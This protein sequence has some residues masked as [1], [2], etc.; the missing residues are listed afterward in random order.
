MD[1]SVKLA[2]EPS[3]RLSSRV[4]LGHWRRPGGVAGLALAFCLLA[5][6]A[7]ADSS[8]PL[9]AAYYDR[10]MA[11]ID[12]AAYVWQGSSRPKRVVTD[13]VQVGVGR[14]NYYVL[15]SSGDLLG[16]RDGFSQPETVISGVARFAAG[17]TGVLA[18]KP[19]GTLWWIDKLSR[20]AVKIAEDV[21]KA[22]V[23]DGANYYIT[24]S[25]ALYVRGKAHRGQYGDGRLA[26]TENFVT[27]ASQVSQITAH[28]GH[29]IL[30]KKNGDVLGTGGNIYGPV[31]K[32]GLGDKAIRW[33]KILSGATA[34]ATGSSHS[35]AIRKDGT[36]Y[37]WGS[38]YGTE[39]VAILD[40]VLAVAAGSSTTI[41]LTQDGILW[42]WKR[43]GKPR[44]HSLD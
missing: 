8:S 7:F 13:A 34:I 38:E 31:G 26:T 27:T 16:Y 10:Q 2:F 37:A 15:T 9:L 6:P 43:G 39:P 5:A 41:A 21:H 18:I 32:Y 12:G 40:K 14:T 4:G 25:G 29:A 3:V 1:R 33:S 17:R 22:A 24:K 35:L 28:T 19:D 20:K 36:L 44:A 30:L 11:I 42:Q 23:G